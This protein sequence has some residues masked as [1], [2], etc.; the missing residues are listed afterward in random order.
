MCF[1]FVNYLVSQSVTG[2]ALFIF[3]LYLRHISF[4]R[5]FYRKQNICMLNML[6]FDVFSVCQSL[7]QSALFF[8]I[9][10]IFTVFALNVVFV[11]LKNISCVKM[12]NFSL[13][14]PFFC[15][16]TC[17]SDLSFWSYGQFVLAFLWCTLTY[18]NYI[19]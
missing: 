4:D 17:L 12:Q 2:I 15:M 5:K 14:A 18:Q 8:N 11:N 1:H 9:T 6:P 19:L 13:S 10:F 3:W 16:K 7:S